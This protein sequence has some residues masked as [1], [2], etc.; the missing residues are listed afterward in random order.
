MSRAPFHPDDKH[1]FPL[2]LVYI[3]KE[4]DEEEQ[5]MGRRWEVGLVMSLAAA[6]LWFGLTQTY[7]FFESRSTY[8]L[9]L[10]PKAMPSG[11]SGPG[12]SRLRQPTRAFWPRRIS[13]SPTWQGTALRQRRRRAPLR[14]GST[15]S[16][17][18]R[19]PT[20]ARRARSARTCPDRSPPG[21]AR[22]GSPRPWGVRPRR[23]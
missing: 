17:S 10:A 2:V 4:Q 22:G 15:V 6:L 14:L 7:S 5:R 11:P 12:R 8:S 23:R 20:P 9:P 18:A 3:N 16:R 21:T 1:I 13:S 19:R